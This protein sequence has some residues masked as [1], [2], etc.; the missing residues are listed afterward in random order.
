LANQAFADHCGT[1]RT[2]QIS[3]ANTEFGRAAVTRMAFGDP[4]WTPDWSVGGSLITAV[5]T[6]ERMRLPRNQFLLSFLRQQLA[7]A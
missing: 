7:A 3:E 6:A 4:N 1:S 2:I 5:S